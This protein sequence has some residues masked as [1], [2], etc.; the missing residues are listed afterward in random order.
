MHNQ[1]IERLW[2]ELRRVVLRYNETLFYSL[3]E[4]RALEQLNEI[5][6]FCLHYVFLP[7]ITRSINEFILQWNNHPLRTERGRS[8]RQLFELAMAFNDDLAERYFSN[9]DWTLYGIGDEHS[10]DS[11]SESVK[12]Q[13]EGIIVPVHVEGGAN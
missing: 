3:E 5:H 10:G 7:R 6:I 11:D 1:R 2:K 8:P 9:V 12:N 13:E 4:S